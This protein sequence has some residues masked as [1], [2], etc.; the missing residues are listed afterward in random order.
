MIRCHEAYYVDPSPE[1]NPLDL[2]EKGPTSTVLTEAPSAHEINFCL[3]KATSPLIDLTRGCK[4][5]HAH[6]D[7]RIPEWLLLCGGPYYKQ[8]PRNATQ[9]TRDHRDSVRRRLRT[10]FDTFYWVV[11]AGVRL[12]HNNWEVTLQGVRNLLDIDLAPYEEEEEAFAVTARQEDVDKRLKDWG[13]DGL[14]DDMVRMVYSLDS[15]VMG[16]LALFGSLGLFTRNWPANVMDDFMLA[17]TE[18]AVDDPGFRKTRTFRYLQRAAL[19]RWSLTKIRKMM[20][21]DPYNVTWLNDA[22]ERYC[23]NAGH[24][25]STFVGSYAGR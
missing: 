14:R 8:R 5:L 21:R 17:V 4:Y 20:S 11:K 3:D 6:E 10:A 23:R 15:L 18:R 9:N 16:Y 22:R 12:S 25:N 2:L 13:V 1:E 19:H 24:I 7:L